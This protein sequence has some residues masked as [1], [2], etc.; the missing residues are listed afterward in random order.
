MKPPERTWQIRYIKLLPRVGSSTDGLFLATPSGGEPQEVIVKLADMLGRFMELE[1]DIDTSNVEHPIIRLGTKAILA[2]LEERDEVDDTILLS[3]SDYPGHPERP[4]LDK[5]CRH[6]K[7]PPGKMLCGIASSRDK[8]LGMTNLRTCEK[9]GY[10]F[11]ILECQHLVNAET[12][13]LVEG[14]RS[15]VNAGCALG[16]PDFFMSKCPTRECFE[17]LP[18]S[19]GRPEEKPRLGFV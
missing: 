17:P 5:N 18:I 15:V 10:P 11:L 4:E 9:C 16:Q 3:S 13:G 12:I 2:Q 1:L 7:T 6:L 19:F 14:V 8:W